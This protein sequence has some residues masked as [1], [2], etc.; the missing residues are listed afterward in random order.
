MNIWS[1][2]ENK[3]ETLNQ[4]KADEFDA[5]W[6]GTPAPVVIKEMRPEADPEDH[7]RAMHADE[8]YVG[9]LNRIRAAFGQDAVQV[10]PLDE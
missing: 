3:A 8:N 7:R 10:E 2:A 1:D 9:H 6:S 4:R 5:L